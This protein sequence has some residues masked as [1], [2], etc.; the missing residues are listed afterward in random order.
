L[1]SNDLILRCYAQAVEK[2]SAVPS[3]PVSES[4]RYFENGT[5]RAVDRDKLRVIQTPQTFRTELLLPAYRQP[6]NASFTDEAT[7]A[8]AHGTP[9]QLIEG[10]LANIK[11]TVPEDMVIAEVLLNARAGKLL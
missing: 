7:V 9:V 11:I 3:I 6:Y 2:G 1:I 10:L 8:E 5:S 4:M